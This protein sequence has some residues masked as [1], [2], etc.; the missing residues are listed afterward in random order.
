MA[1]TQVARMRSE[2]QYRK[3]QAEQQ[4]HNAAN[5]PLMHLLARAGYVALGVVYV[6]VGGLAAKA[7]SAGSGATT[8]QTGALA[9]IY[10]EPFGQVLLG[11]VC[12]GLVAFGLYSFGVARYRRLGTA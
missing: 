11:I 7:A 3:N 2:A 12:V 6:I 10:H 1:N 8:G 4:A 5:S 9:A